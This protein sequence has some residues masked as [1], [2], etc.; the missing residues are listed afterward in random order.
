MGVIEVKRA[1]ISII[2]PIYNSEKYLE[3]CMESVVRQ[4]YDNLQIICV[5]G[6]STDN[7]LKIIEAFQNEDSRI[8]LIQKANEGV[9]IA[10]NAALEKANGDFVL[11]VD[12]DDWLEENTCE[13]AL[14][15][16][17]TNSAD[18][19]MWPY[20]R[21]MKGESRKKEI[22]ITDICFEEEKVQDKLHRRMVGL[23][24]E[25]LSEPENADALC[26]VWGKLYKRS[27]ISDNDILFHD[28]R[29][30][31]TYEDGLFNL[32]YFKYVKK[33]YFLN[34]YLYHYRRDNVSSIT[35][36]YNPQL[37]KCW[38]RLFDI[39]DQYIKNEKLD[40]CYSIALDN[41]RALSLIVLGINVVS[42]H[43]SFVKKIKEIDKIINDEKY[44]K[45]IKSLE[46]EYFPMHWKLFFG[47]AK[48]KFSFGT[49]VLIKVI[50]VIR[51]K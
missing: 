47:F 33:A 1:K 13:L 32:H 5:D 25:E 17:Q 46:I 27:I 24:K 19:V 9:S 12:S 44:V 8:E 37:L 49:Y 39:M 23:Y 30:I 36:S 18:V 21:E 14:T 40:N 2:I 4:T 34:Q 45:A 26:T 43:D 28:I 7:S 6:N 20:I 42:N 29:E 16:I 50:Q 22:F 38:Q 10:R 31:G 41:R 48:L 11:F 15:C 35:N 51:G 3:K